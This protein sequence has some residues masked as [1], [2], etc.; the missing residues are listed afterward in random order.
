MLRRHLEIFKVAQKNINCYDIVHVIAEYA[1]PTSLDILHMIKNTHLAQDI[2]SDI[3]T[4]TI[5]IDSFTHRDIAGPITYYKDDR[6]TEY[7]GFTDICEGFK[8]IFLDEINDEIAT[9]L[10]NIAIGDVFSIL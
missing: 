1:K 8:K 9:T 7:I 5:S 6:S 3:R 4:L 2:K 10:L